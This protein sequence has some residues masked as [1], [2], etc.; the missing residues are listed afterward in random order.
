MFLSLLLAPIVLCSDPEFRAGKV[1]LDELDGWEC[2]NA[3]QVQF[4]GSAGAQEWDRVNLTQAT[5]NGAK[6]NSVK[7][8]N[9]ELLKVYVHDSSLRNVELSNNQLKNLDFL[10]T[11]INGVTVRNSAGG[12]WNL[13]QSS[14]DSIRIMASEIEAVKVRWSSVTRFAAEKGKLSRW[15]VADSK[16]KTLTLSGATVD[17]F[18][19]LRTPVQLLQASAVRGNGFSFEDVTLQAGKF[20]ATRIEG[21][22]WLRSGLNNL[23]ILNSQWRDWRLSDSTQFFQVTI[24]GSKII[25]PVWVRVGIDFAKFSNTTFAGARFERVKI[26][27]S[28]FENVH[29][30]NS[31]LTGLE[32]GEAVDFVNCTY[33]AGTKLP[34]SREDAAAR[35]LLPKP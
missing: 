25:S 21:L 23:E 13:D 12:W 16:F 33:D 4:T 9:S 8:Y 14:V 10:K 6:L 17:G 18:T 20:T 19:L 1:R 24:S 3:N 34:W 7:W 22:N 32:I 5:F 30:E 35:G 28:R 26:S 29:F 11:I 15:V 31:E 2:V 27:H